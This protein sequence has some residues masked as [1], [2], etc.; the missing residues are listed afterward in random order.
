MRPLAGGSVR[1]FNS[2]IPR[3]LVRTPAISPDGKNIIFQVRHDGV[4]MLDLA[5]E[6]MRR[7]LEDPS[8]EEFTWSADGRRVAYHSRRS[9]AWG[10]WIMAPR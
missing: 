9:G 10:V 8:A 4:W 5:D 1:I 7:I 3:R 6:S 2:P